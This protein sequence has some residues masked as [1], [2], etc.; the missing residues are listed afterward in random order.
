METYRFSF[1]N[2]AINMYTLLNQ[3]DALSDATLSDAT[4]SSTSTISVLEEDSCLKRFFYDIIKDANINEAPIKDISTILKRIYSQYDAIIPGN[5]GISKTNLIRLEEDVSGNDEIKPKVT[6][7]QN[8][9]K[10]STVGSN[11]RISDATKVFCESGMGPDKIC[12]G[13]FQK[14][15]TPAGMLDSISKG[16]GDYDFPPSN[17]TIQFDETFT[18]RLGFPEN[19]SWTTTQMPDLSDAYSVTIKYTDTQEDILSGDN[20]TYNSK[21]GFSEL[22]IGNKEKNILI[23]NPSTSDKL[24]KNLLLIK[25]LG[26]VA[27]VWMYLAYVMITAANKADCIMITTDGVVFL[28]CELLNLSCIYT[29][30]RAG[31]ERGC[32]TLKHY[33]SGAIDYRLKILNMLDNKYKSLYSN[34]QA[35]IFSLNSVLPI[36]NSRSAEDV[37]FFCKPY[38]RNASMNYI[39]INVS[40]FGSYPEIITILRNKINDVVELL[41]SK[42][43]LLQRIYDRHKELSMNN[44][45]NSENINEKYGEFLTELLAEGDF[46]VPQIITRLSNNKFCLNNVGE[47]DMNILGHFLNEWNANDV[48]KGEFT[49]SRGAYKG[50]IDFGEIKELKVVTKE[51]LSREQEQVLAPEQGEASAPSEAFAPAPGEE[52]LFGGMSHQV[53]GDTSIGE[54][55][56]YRFEFSIL[57]YILQF[58]MSDVDNY[59]QDISL[60][61][62][63][64][65]RKNKLDSFKIDIKGKLEQIKFAVL[66]DLYANSLN[67]ESEQSYY[68]EY[69]LHNK[70]IDNTPM[71]NK[72]LDYS[73]SLPI[74]EIL[75]NDLA[76]YLSRYIDF[77]EDFNEIVTDQVM[78]A[79]AMQTQ[80]MQV[81]PAAFVYDR[82]SPEPIMSE[83]QDFGYFSQMSQSP[84]PPPKRRKRRGLENISEG[85]K[86]TRKYK[87]ILRKKT[88]RNKKVNRKHKTIK[89][90][91]KQKKHTRR[92]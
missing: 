44:S 62:T 79:Q 5:P 83:S 51:E 53:G 23:I 16:K 8:I 47:R 32:C 60:E 86:R 50:E 7:L 57:I 28:F 39:Y 74:D 41:T 73:K 11:T 46:I 37:G 3:N 31:V 38:G 9:I 4:L 91:N 63:L 12:T 82:G 26:D 61:L 54:Y 59:I 77:G 66:Y 68:S 87:K 14:I 78:Q 71:L 22:V 2:N 29:G 10:T 81:P 75:Y 52:P 18:K 21:G 6:V 70:S 90:R 15:G 20:I 49:L 24:R 88:R 85:G 27:Q 67:I 55:E 45:I 58:C 13:D 48:S 42:S 25:E 64:A 80:A 30:A 84:T 92:T 34:I 89:K 35:I 40:K 36:I 19:L 17:K 76:R 33:M 43:D 72:I 65:D 56:I 69:V 1:N